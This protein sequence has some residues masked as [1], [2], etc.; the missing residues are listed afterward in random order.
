[1]RGLKRLVAG[2]CLAA[3]SVAPAGAVGTFVGPDGSTIAM[4][5]SRSLLVRHADRVELITQVKYA[6]TP[7]DFVWLI[8]VPNVPNARDNNV[9]ASP[10]SQ[11]VLDEL[12]DTTHPVLDGVC[13]GMPT[14]AR[15]NERQADEWGPVPAG[16]LTGRVFEAAEVE[17]GELTEF[18]T[19]TRGYTVDE[20][21]Q[22]AIDDT[23][24][25]NYMFIAVHIDTAALGTQKLDP[26]ISVTWPEGPGALRVGT[27]PIATAIP[28]GVAD[29]VF[30]TL[31]SGRANGNLMTRELDFGA[32]AFTGPNQTDYR[33]QFD[34]QVAPLQT[35]VFVTEF[36]GAVDNT[37]FQDE[38]LE[39]LRSASGASFLTRLHARMS[40]AVFRTNGKTFEFSPQ[41]SGAYAR[42][43]E[44]TGLNC[45]GDEPDM[46]MGEVDM[47]TG[48]ADM[49]GEEPALDMGGTPNADMG[50]SGGGGG[51]GGCSADPGR[52]TPWA[53]ALLLGLPL[54]AR[55]RRR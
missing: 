40:A 32:M 11:A 54:L 29:L 15:A 45:G 44:I 18:L 21:L 12:S 53:W 43:H 7:A 34:A 36:A 41:G 1:M 51:G 22:A 3:L 27:R 48:E 16:G 33:A 14:G 31:D 49:G 47:A 5:A 19:T 38:G 37:T 52:G 42:E 55:R 28:E 50:S 13:D 4:E 39:N 10:A 6:G 26:I 17:A 2:A 46:A 24:N 20:A 25:Q 8:A 35:Q 30:F 23:L 9:T